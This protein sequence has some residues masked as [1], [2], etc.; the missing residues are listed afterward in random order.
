MI[1][2]GCAEPFARSGDDVKSVMSGSLTFVAVGSEYGRI[3][4]CYCA[5]KLIGENEFKIPRKALGRARIVL[6]DVSYPAAN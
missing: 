6:L 2:V 5:A 4:V 1:A 3:R